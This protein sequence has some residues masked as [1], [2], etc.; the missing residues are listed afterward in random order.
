M[1]L[2]PDAASGKIRKNMGDARIAI[3]AYAA[4]LDVTR[5]QLES[6]PRREMETVLTTLRLNF[7]EKSGAAGDGRREGS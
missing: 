2:V 6:G 5:E 7:V 4:I 3:D 1:G